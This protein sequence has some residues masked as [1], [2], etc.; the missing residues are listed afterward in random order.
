MDDEPEEE[1]AV[2]D[3][4]AQEQAIER[5]RAQAR[6]RHEPDPDAGENDD[7]APD[8]VPG[9]ITRGNPR[10]AEHSRKVHGAFSRAVK[11]SSPYSDDLTEEQKR[12]Q[13]HDKVKI[14][15]FEDGAAWVGGIVFGG[16][17][18]D[19]IEMLSDP[20][21]YAAKRGQHHVTDYN[22]FFKSNAES[23]GVDYKSVESWD[24]SFKLA[25]PAWEAGLSTNP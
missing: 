21:G 12:W 9:I 14:N 6:S 22:E 1:K 17:I 5:Q 20:D 23:M 25:K 15:N 10:L 18:Y 3:A 13:A 11:S 24:E 7:T 2:H 8:P 4:I 19:I 16:W